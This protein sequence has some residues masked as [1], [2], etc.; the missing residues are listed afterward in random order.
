MD[1]RGKR[2]FSILISYFYPWIFYKFFIS[3]QSNLLILICHKL[4][5]F[6]LILI[7][8][9]DFFLALLKKFYWF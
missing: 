3:F 9:Y 1:L 8:I 7:F 6:N 2:L 4:F 5:F